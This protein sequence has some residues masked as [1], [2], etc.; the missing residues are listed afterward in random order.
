ME[1]QL[2]ASFRFSFR[3]GFLFILTSFG[4]SYADDILFSLLSEGGAHN[5]VVAEPTASCNRSI[6]G[7]CFNGDY[8]G[9]S[10]AHCA[11]SLG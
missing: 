10:I 9:L 1:A 2:K 7:E 3:F 11:V 4:T 6:D 8:A 5:L